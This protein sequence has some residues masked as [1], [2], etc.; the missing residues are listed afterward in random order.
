MSYINEV[1]RYT[2]DTTGQTVATVPI[3]APV[4][5]GEFIVMPVNIPAG[6]SVAISSVTD[7][8][9]NT[10]T[11]RATENAATANYQLYV[12]TCIPT[13]A[14]T[15]S[16]H[17]TITAASSITKWMVLA[18]HFD[19][20]T[21][22]D[23]SAVGTST[24]STM[25]TG[26]TATAANND[27]LLY[28]AF[29]WTDASSTV[30]MTPAAGFDTPA[31]GKAT[32]SPSSAP[33]ALESQWTYVSTPGTRSSG[34]TLSSTQGSGG[35]ILALNR[36]VSIPAAGTFKD[37]FANTCGSVASA[38]P[39]VTL[40]S[41]I[42]NFDLGVML[43]G[44]NLNATVTPPAGWSIA[45]GP[46]LNSFNNECVTLL[47]KTLV[48]G[49]S[50]TT[51]TATL[52]AAGKWAVAGVLIGGE[53]QI[54]V[55]T[56]FQGPNESS[57]AVTVPSLTPTRANELLVVLAYA[58]RPN[59]PVTF[60]PPSGYT[61]G[62]DVATSFGTAPQFAAYAATKQLSS[63]AGVPSGSSA[64]TLDSAGNASGWVIAISPSVP[65]P[66]THVIYLLNAGPTL[67]P[68]D[69]TEL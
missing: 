5:V 49:D 36:N 33:R 41:G 60:T 20:I 62:K 44:T 40:P 43:I 52:S 7:S 1:A 56:Y 57:T 17:I 67:V 37:S 39:S 42:R 50:G 23:V 69:L 13:T 15:T 4:P 51:V 27:Q 21:S 63:G 59:T 26:T 22:F 65:P 58:R 12:Y 53:T 3:L 66:A 16:D 34:A 19:D 46:V 64:L 29:A 47:T 30:A 24:T 48:A 61:E 35:V 14:L 68:L 18:H 45:A 2:H 28:C 9:G 31:A 54:D 32:C 11:L 55:D 25:T 8:K 38:S 10:W 6:I